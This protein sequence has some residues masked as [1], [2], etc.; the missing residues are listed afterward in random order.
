[1]CADD[2][3]VDCQND[4]TNDAENVCFEKMSEEESVEF[5][6]DTYYRYE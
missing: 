3:S 4:S 2:K 6:D 5:F 1:M